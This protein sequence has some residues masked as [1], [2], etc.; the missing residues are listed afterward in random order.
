MNDLVWYYVDRAQ[1]RQGPVSA[2]AVADAW[3]AGDADDTSLAWHEGLPEWRPLA[4]F[5]DLLGLTAETRS[6]IP[7]SPAPVDLPAASGAP[8]AGATAWT[9]AQA[10]ATTAARSGRGCLVAALIGAAVILLA[11][12]SIL[13]AVA[14]PAYQEYVE[15]A[16][17]QAGDDA[18]QAADPDTPQPEADGDLPTGDGP[19]GD[20]VLLAA[21]AEARSLQPAVDAFVLNTDRCPRDGTEVGLQPIALPGVVAIAVGEARTGM[22]TITVEF[23][24]EDAESL[25]GERLAL[26]RDVA[27]DWYCTSE[28]A[29]RDRLPADCR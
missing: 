25:A 9:A 14:I 6:A 18:G 26:S 13:A 22:C 23:G 27:G 17:A 10:P 8:A 4:E 3:R 15:R 20:A 21:L 16:K 11:F 29:D 5:R 1:Q 12:V 19:T 28:M 7:T 24:G 2:G